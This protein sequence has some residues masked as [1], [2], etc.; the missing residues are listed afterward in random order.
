MTA[1]N[2]PAPEAGEL[3]VLHVEDNEV[4]AE[5]VAQ[6]LR[7]GGFSASVVVVQSEDEFERELRLHRPDVVLADYNL[8]QWTGMGALDVLRRAGL[9]IPLILVSGA[10]GDVTAVECIKRGATDYVLKDGL[11]RL[12]E[13]KRRLVRAVKLEGESIADLAARTG[14][15]EVS[16]KVTVHRALK[17]ISEELRDNNADG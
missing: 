11:A 1:T 13:A 14:Q 6:A 2:H 10:L 9:D 12:P 7:K 4:D 8:P 16:V 3:R 15:S 17:S 5:L